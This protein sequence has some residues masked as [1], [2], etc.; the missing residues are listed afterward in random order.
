MWCIILK[1]NYSSCINGLRLLKIISENKK[2]KCV[3]YWLLITALAFNISLTSFAQQQPTDTVG[4]TSTVSST[5]EQDEDKSLSEFKKQNKDNLDVVRVFS[6]LLALIL[7]MFT[8]AWLYK[9]YGKNFLSKTMLAQNPNRNAI[10]IVS[11]TP[12]GQNKYLHI[13]EVGQERM[14]IGATN[15]NI[16]LIKNL[17]ND[18]PKEKVVSDE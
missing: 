9:K 10:N 17:Q 12:I 7:I 6:N 4:E 2:I 13:I 3:A 8:L 18:N 1:Y 5:I 11:T 14:L 15:T 16:S